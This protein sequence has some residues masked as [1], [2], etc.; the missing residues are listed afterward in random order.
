MRTTLFLN[1]LRI[2]LGVSKQRAQTPFVVVPRRMGL[3][4]GMSYDNV[5][6]LLDILE[7]TSTGDYS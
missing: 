6:E 4:A 1:L 3:P 2:R 7:A 5:E